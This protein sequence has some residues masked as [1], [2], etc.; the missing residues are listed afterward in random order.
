MDEEVKDRVTPIDLDKLTTIYI[1]IRDKRADNKRMFDAEDTDLKEQME[2][3]EAQMLD[4]CKEMNADSIRTPHG[5]IMRSIKSRYWTNDWDS[6][7]TFIEETSAFGLLEKRLH[8]TNMRDFLAENPDLYPMGL[9]VESEFT[10]V[11][12]RSKEK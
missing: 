10:V 8:Q 2:V 12:R 7:Y 3:L 5:T 11:V 9:N 4:V 6:M 1:K